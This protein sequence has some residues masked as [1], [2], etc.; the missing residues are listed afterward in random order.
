M[1]FPWSLNR[2]RIQLVSTR[3]QVQSLTLLSGL[4]TQHCHK[5][6]CRLQMPLGS[7]VA[8]AVV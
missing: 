7:G 8:V 4:R 5:L 2:L 1:E 3:M 6:W